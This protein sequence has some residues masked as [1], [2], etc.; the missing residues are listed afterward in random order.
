MAHREVDLTAGDL[1][2]REFALLGVS[3]GKNRTTKEAAYG[4]LRP[5]GQG[6]RHKEGAKES[7]DRKLLPTSPDPGKPQ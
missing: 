3:R 6:R 1:K 4:M 7:P 5:T 2:P